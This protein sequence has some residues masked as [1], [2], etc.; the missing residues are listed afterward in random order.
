MEGC[1]GKWSNAGSLFLRVPLGLFF[2]MAGISKLS[3]PAGFVAMVNGLVDENIS[4]LPDSLATAYAYAL[5]YVEIVVGAAAI[6]GF[7]TKWAGLLMSLLL[8]SF[9][10]AFGVTAKGVPFNKDVVFLGAAIYLAL[11]G[12]YFWSIDGMMKKE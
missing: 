10:V 7:L 9:L 3:D 5:P 1:C 12:S 11:S 8:I 6:L 2:L 4:W